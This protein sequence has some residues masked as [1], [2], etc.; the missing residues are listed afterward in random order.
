[1]SEPRIYLGLVLVVLMYSLVGPEFKRQ[2]RKMH[3]EW[4]Q[5]DLMNGGMFILCSIFLLGCELL[6]L[7]WV[8]A[9]ATDPFLSNR[10]ISG[11]VL[12]SI[13]LIFRYHRNVRTASTGNTKVK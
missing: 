13:A 7:R 2:I 12:L 8:F 5:E 1:M 11:M 3:R 4:K 6:M 10:A 9:I